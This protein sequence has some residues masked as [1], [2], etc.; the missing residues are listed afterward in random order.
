MDSLDFVCTNPYYYFNDLL[1]INKSPQLY[2]KK[3]EEEGRKTRVRH[4]AWI[5]CMRTP[6]YYLDEI[7]NTNKPYSYMQL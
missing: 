7:L 1:I 2:G 6:F 3:G 5:L 4:I